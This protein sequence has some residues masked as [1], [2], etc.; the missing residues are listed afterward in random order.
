MGVLGS[1]RLST[2]WELPGYQLRG[3]WGPCPCLGV[4][5]TVSLLKTWPLFFLLR[6]MPSCREESARSQKEGAKVE[7]G[8]GRRS[9][10]ALSLPSVLCK[11]LE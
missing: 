4:P 1:S 3:P 10:G 2:F 11:P 8:S 6:W 9:T 5:R 7:T